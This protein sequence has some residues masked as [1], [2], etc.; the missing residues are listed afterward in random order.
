MDVIEGGNLIW[1]MEGKRQRLRRL[2]DFIRSY[3]EEFYEGCPRLFLYSFIKRES[4]TPDWLH[5]TLRSLEKKN[6][7][8]TPCKDHYHVIAYEML[9]IDKALYGR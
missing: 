2:L 5:S 4:L 1:A 6:V 8:M 3:E 9:D 7:I